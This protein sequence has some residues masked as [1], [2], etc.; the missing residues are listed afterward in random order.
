M[1]NICLTPV[2]AFIYLTCRRTPQS[3][4]T[5]GTDIAVCNLKPLCSWMPAVAAVCTSDALVACVSFH[6]AGDDLTASPPVGDS[7]G[8]N[9]DG[10]PTLREVT[11]TGSPCPPA[12][13]PP[14]LFPFPFFMVPSPRVCEAA[15]SGFPFD[16]TTPS[17]LLPTT[18]PPPLSLSLLLPSAGWQKRRRCTK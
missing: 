9:E 17:H 12:A 5:G 4:L 18:H 10:W 1:A 15:G 3:H 8:P 16:G 13:P 11:I 14:V 2:F 7:S 6:P